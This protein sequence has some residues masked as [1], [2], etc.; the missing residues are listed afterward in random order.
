MTDEMPP[1]RGFGAG[2]MDAAI[3]RGWWEHQ[4]RAHWRAAISA[5]MMNRMPLPAPYY[6]DLLSLAAT[7]IAEA[8]YEFRYELV[9]IVAQMACEVVVEQTL[10]PLLKGKKPPITFNLAS[11]ALSKYTLLTHDK[12][13]T[14]KSFWKPFTCHSKR[15]NKVVHGKARVNQAEA[16]DSLT[17]ATEFVDHVEK[18]R[19]ESLR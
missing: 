14:K 12:S 18:V 15:R 1:G 16:Q 13:I 19:G 2:P 8:R 7:L 5:N 3:M 4:H 10:T 9:V 17:V 11:R 6:R